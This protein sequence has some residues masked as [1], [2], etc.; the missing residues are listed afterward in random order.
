MDTHIHDEPR[1][2]AAAE[3]QMQAWALTQETADRAIQETLHRRLAAS[4]RTYVAISRETGVGASAIGRLVGERLGWEV[5]DKSI[6]DRVAERLHEP[7]SRLDVI[8]ETSPNWVY[9]V[10]G[11][12][13]DNRLVTHEKLLGGLRRVI[14]A[15]GRRGKVVIVGRGAQFLLPPDKG[16]VVRLVASDKYRIA[17]I[18][19]RMAASES[20]ARRFMLKMD[21]DRQE[22]IAKCFHRDATDPH[23]Y[24]LVLNVESLGQQG[25]VE[26]ILVALSR[27]N[28]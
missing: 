8:D 25:T 22:F 4:G 12:C 21:H 9:D 14:R 3:R 11:A 27:P 16:L 7:R 18:M 20:Q 28:N 15:L 17:R 13:M 26:Q 2:V 5:F 23:L 1:L 24:D 6:L 19:A 10:L